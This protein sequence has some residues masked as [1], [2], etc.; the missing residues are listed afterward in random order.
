MLLVRPPK[1]EIHP[2]SKILY[3]INTQT[4]NTNKYTTKLTA[5]FLIIHFKTFH[6][7][8]F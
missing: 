5:L 3:S 2:S 8:K 4:F 1:T 6:V 7:N